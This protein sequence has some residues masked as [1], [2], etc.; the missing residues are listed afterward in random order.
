MINSAEGLFGVFKR[1]MTGVYQHCSEGHLQR[2][3]GMWTNSRSVTRAVP[4][5]GLNTERSA[6]VVAG[7]EGKRLMWKELTGKAE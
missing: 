4:G 2:Y 3:N 1:G 5:W 7:G 6:I